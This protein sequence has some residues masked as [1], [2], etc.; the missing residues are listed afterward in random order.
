MLTRLAIAAGTAAL[1]G[2]VA[3]APNPASADASCTAEAY[4]GGSVRTSI[5]MPATSVISPFR[6]WTATKTAS[7]RGQACREA[8]AELMQFLRANHSVGGVEKALCR[9]AEHPDG[10]WVLANWPQPGARV[11]ATSLVVRAAED[12][13]IHDMIGLPGV[14]IVCE[15]AANHEH[16]PN[17]AFCEEFARV[18]NPFRNI[19]RALRCR[20][21]DRPGLPRETQT[22]ASSASHEEWVDYCVRNRDKAFRA[23]RTTVHRANWCMRDKH[24]QLIDPTDRSNVEA[25]CRRYSRYYANFNIY[26]NQFSDQ[27]VNSQI[28]YRTDLGQSPNPSATCTWRLPHQQSVLTSAHAYRAC[29]DNAEHAARPLSPRS[30]LLHRVGGVL[31]TTV[32]CDRGSTV[33]ECRPSYRYISRMIENYRNCYRVIVLGSLWLYP[34]GETP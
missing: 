31:S 8:V 1:L 4:G 19:F 18:T 29:M 9:R 3:G 20:D 13:D 2:I 26:M 12:H 14:E 10:G 34:T 23:A 6:D 7:S 32:D 17:G 22:P 25:Y 16:G 24:R 33:P 30:T 27:I 5:E 15:D 21:P 11:R 28:R